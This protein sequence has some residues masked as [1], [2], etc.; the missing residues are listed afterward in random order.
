MLN[1][2][3]YK[4]QEAYCGPA[5]LK[6]VLDYYGIRKTEEELAKLCKT[7]KKGGTSAKDILRV[8]NHFDL[9]GFIKDHATLNDLKK[10][11]VQK[12][13]PVIVNW[14]ST[15]EGHYSPVIHIDEKT[16]CLQDPEL[17]KIRAMSLTTFKRVWFDFFG[18]YLRSKKDIILRRMIVLYKNNTKQ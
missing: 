14:F 9:T 8:A 15:D 1:V 3:P 11:V 10:Y 4:Q 17:G 5:S 7:T 16:I 13:I 2:K 12:R 18:D 6:M